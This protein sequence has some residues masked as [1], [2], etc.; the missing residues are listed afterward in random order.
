MCLRDLQH[1]TSLRVLRLRGCI[2]ITDAGLRPLR[3]L[4]RLEALE[5]H[6]ALGITW[7]GIDAIS[8]LTA[9][10]ARYFAFEFLLPAELHTTA[11]LL[12]YLAGPRAPRA[13]IEH[14]RHEFELTAVPSCALTCLMMIKRYVHHGL[15]KLL[16]GCLPCATPCAVVDVVGRHGLCNGPMLLHTRYAQQ[17]VFQRAFC[18][19]S[20]YMLSAYLSSGFIHCHTATCM[21]GHHACMQE[22]KLGDVRSV[23]EGGMAPLSTLTRLKALHLR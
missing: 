22:L 6:G 16:A 19:R 5:L 8:S 10:Q 7:M 11:D 23:S 14:G 4:S 21:F 12:G 3:C 9:L 17:Q 1:A 18:K 15:L 13:S 2:D 20:L